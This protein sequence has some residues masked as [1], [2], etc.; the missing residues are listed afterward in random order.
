MAHIVMYNF[1]HKSKFHYDMILINNF[2]IR[3]DEISFQI[4]AKRKKKLKTLSV[5]NGWSRLVVLLFRDP[6]LLECT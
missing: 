5:Y 2:L 3:Y 1:V 4:V 6:H